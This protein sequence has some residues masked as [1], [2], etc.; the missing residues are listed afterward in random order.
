MQKRL[1]GSQKYKLHEKYRRLKYIMEIYFTVL[2]LS[3]TFQVRL[4][5]GE[6]MIREI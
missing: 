4:V 6:V 3:I 2:T 5:M 1:H